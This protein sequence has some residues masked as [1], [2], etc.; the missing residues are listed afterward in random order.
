M[1]A[2]IIYGIRTLE[3][4]TLASIELGYVGQTRQGIRSRELQHREEQPW[5]DV[6]VGSA[7]VIASGVWSNE[8]LDLTEAWAIKLLR[9]RYNVSGNETNHDRILPPDA[10]DQRLAR[11]RVHG[12]PLWFPPAPLPVVRQ[13]GPHAASQ[14][15]KRR[16]DRASL[17]LSNGHERILELIGA[18]VASP[19]QLADAT[20][21]SERQVHNL[22]NELRDCYRRIQRAGHGVYVLVEALP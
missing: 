10:I 2:G 14:A 15:Q 9:P 7:Y 12:I 5:A 19:R 13:R 3:P 22:L 17:P 8:E 4:T 20:G 18:G 6:I 11:D 21:Y 1:S 16:N